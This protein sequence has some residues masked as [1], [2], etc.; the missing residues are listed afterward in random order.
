MRDVV[1]QSL[2]NHEIS[3]ILQG[4]DIG[5]FIKSQN[6]RQFGH[7][8]IM[9]HGKWKH[10]NGKWEMEIGNGNMEIKRMTE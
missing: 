7:M 4:A 8:K 3:N 10:G 9:E 2:M 5:K 6:L 1:Y